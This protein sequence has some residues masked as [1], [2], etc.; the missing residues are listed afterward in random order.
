MFLVATITRRRSRYF[1]AM[2]EEFRTNIQRFAETEREWERVERKGE[3][4]E[5]RHLTASVFARTARSICF[6]GI[7]SRIFSWN[8]F[9]PAGRVVG[10]NKEVVLCLALPSFY[11]FPRVL[12]FLTRLSPFLFDLLRSQRDSRSF[13]FPSTPPSKSTAPRY[14]TSRC[15]CSLCPRSRL[16]LATPFLSPRDQ[17]SLE[18]LPGTRAYFAAARRDEYL[19]L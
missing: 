5:E 7:F 14:S 10:R 4:K 11:S 19:M 9:H 2:T 12:V 15:T 8:L 17:R 13:R 6:S 3:G 16:P 1:C 18:V